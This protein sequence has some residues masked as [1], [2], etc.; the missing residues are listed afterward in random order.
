MLCPVALVVLMLT[1]LSEPW[2]V[3]V[4]S[5]IVG[6]TDALSMP[7]FQTIAPSLVRQ[8]QIGSAIALTSSPL[9]SVT[10]PPCCG[11]NGMAGD[12]IPFPERLGRKPTLIA[13]T[14]HNCPPQLPH[15][16]PS[17]RASIRSSAVISCTRPTMPTTRVSRS[18]MT[19]DI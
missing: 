4:L 6:I 2:V 13:R 3:I 10:A 16:S 14:L 15:Q 1:H 9:E 11:H 8:D 5:L 7:S 18:T 17:D 12:D 19:C